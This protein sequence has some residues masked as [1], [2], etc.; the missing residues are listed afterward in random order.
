LRQKCRTMA[1]SIA[2]RFSVQKMAE[3]TI[4]V[5]EQAAALHSTTQGH[6]QRA[7]FVR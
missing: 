6:A 3:Q 2:Q 1:P 7:S 5:Y 4:R